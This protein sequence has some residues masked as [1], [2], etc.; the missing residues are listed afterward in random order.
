MLHE[1]PPDMAGE[2]AAPATSHL[3]QVNEDT[4]KLDKDTAQ[5]FHDNMAKLLFLCK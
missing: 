5:L 1:V 2:A 3:F 4:T